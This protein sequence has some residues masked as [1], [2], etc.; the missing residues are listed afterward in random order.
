MEFSSTGKIL[1]MRICIFR[2]LPK[3]ELVLLLSIMFVS[4]RAF[5]QRP[6][7]YKE[8]R[9]LEDYSELKDST[10]LDWSNAIKYI[11]LDK[12]RKS[13]LSF[14]GSI[15]PRY[16][17]LTNQRFIA[18]NN[19]S[20][21]SQR[22]ALH[23]DWHFGEYVRLFGELQHGYAS[24]GYTFLQSDDLAVH[25]GFVELKVGSSNFSFRLGRQEMRLG[26][27]RLYDF[28]K[29]PNIRRTFDLGKITFA[30]KETTIQAF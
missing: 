10:N 1:D 8:Q 17:R 30:Q 14:G 3:K 26:A 6:D 7:G 16:E 23:T 9:A 12:Q 28:G 19:L 4:I 29:G 22:I 21:Y 2:R 5:A 24:Q 25:Q 13:Y 20:Y 18:G 15:R 27:G 11:A